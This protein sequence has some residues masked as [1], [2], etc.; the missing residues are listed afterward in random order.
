MKR[1]LHIVSCLELGGTEAFIMNHYRALNRQEIQ[2]D[3]LVLTEKDF[4]YV[5]EIKELGGN[6]YFGVQAS[7]WHMIKY[8]K[9]FKNVLN[10]SGGYEA[11]HCHLNAGNALPLMGAMLCGI[12]KR[13]SHSHD[14]SQRPGSKV[15]Q[16]I[17]ELRKGIIKLCGNVF[18][19][20][21]ID[22][23]KELYGTRFFE[24]YGKVI[25]NGIELTKFLHIDSREIGKR[26]EEF[27]I[28]QENDF[29]IGNISRFEAKK[30]QLF[31]LEVFKKILDKKPNAILLL[32]G[33]DGGQL[34]EVMARIKMLRIEKNV[35]LIGVRTDIPVCLK[36]MD[37]YL[38]PSL[39]EG[40][41]IALLEAQAAG[42]NCFAS[43]GVSREADMGLNRVEYYNLSDG[44]EAW[45]ERVLQKQA[46]CHRKSQE[47]IVAAF[48][49]KEY[50]I[51]VAV[52]KLKGVYNA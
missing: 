18:L 9:I 19:A 50:T 24:K 39:F 41:G 44:A 23:G 43:T 13:I 37:V 32:G 38:F 8:Y 5:A 12:K 1:I 28:T 22:A 31:I 45:A 10:Q 21:S 52:Q 17:F 46:S 3:F 2:F 16:I 15:K 47:E 26:K 11:V 36:L 35:R 7:F 33:I 14:T 30:N 25:N 20:C 4:P 6:V 51:E 29:I 48:T 27:K 40:L 34:T 49:E 42:C